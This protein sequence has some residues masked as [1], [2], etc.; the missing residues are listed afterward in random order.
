M[1][2]IRVY[3]TGGPE[4]MRLEELETPAPG[5]GQALVRV[6]AA[7]VNFID[8][9]HRTGQYP[10]EVPIAIGLEGA[11][12]VEAAGDGV[13]LAVG[14]RVAWTGVRGSYAT[15]LCV[16]A[17]RLVTIP[18]GVDDQTAAAVMLQG[19]TAHYLTRST[20]PVRA[21]QR[22][23]VH[24]AAGGVGLL[25][26]QLASR[27]GATVIGT[28]STDD[29]RARATGAGAAHVIDYTT[30]DFVAETRRLTGG[31]GVHVVYDSVGRSTFDGSLDCLTSRGMLV[32][33]GQSS[34]PVPPLDLQVLNK[35]GSLFVTR[36]SLFH[37]IAERAEL[38]A[39]ASDL[40][41]WVADGS[42]KVHLDRTLPLADAPEAHRLLE[43]RK[44]SGKILLIPAG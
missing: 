18:D 4:A 28:A 43:S 7:G 37:Y 10:S 3:E 20:F 9:Y 22:C 13:D 35:K 12:T 17:D 14:A 6:A 21:G 38:I 30:A 31:E 24:A 11:G 44:T 8:V 2:A 29:K 19:M 39:R 34:G 42:L 25:L 15:H 26:C 32:L 33:F 5:A 23:L 36:P 27:A 1:R 40:L 16:P 41:G